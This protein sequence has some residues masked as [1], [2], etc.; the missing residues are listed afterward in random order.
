MYIDTH[1]GLLHVCMYVCT[2]V[3]WYVHRSLACIYVLYIRILAGEQ[4]LCR[5]APRS[6]PPSGDSDFWRPIISARKTSG[7]TMIFGYRSSSSENMVATAFLMT[8]RLSYSVSSRSNVMAS[9]SIVSIVRTC[10]P[11]LSEDA[12][13]IVLERNGGA[14]GTECRRAQAAR[15]GQ[16][17][18]WTT[19]LGGQAGL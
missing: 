2:Y 12:C 5:R 19:G 1:T 7:A 14:C 17:F 9:M 18:T 13:M 16:F 6:A 4:D 10:I 11:A 15:I 8:G 3:Y